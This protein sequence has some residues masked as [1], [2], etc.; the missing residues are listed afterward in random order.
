MTT[1]DDGPGPF[2]DFDVVNDLV[3]SGYAVGEADD[4]DEVL[5]RI[6]E[7][8][9]GPWVPPT[10]VERLLYRD[11]DD[12]DVSAYLSILA[13]AGVYH[14]VAIT[15]A[16]PDPEKR[17]P[18]IAELGDGLRAM[19]VYTLD[20]L[21][22]PHPKVVYEF[23]NLRGLLRLLGDVDVLL[24]NPQTPCQNVL[25]L[26]DKMKQLILEM[27]DEYWAPGYFSG[28]VITRQS[29]ATE[30]GVLL[31]GLACGAQLCV[32]NGHAWNT[33]E[34][35][36][37]GYSAELALIEEWW[38]VKIRQDWLEIEG[39]L[40]N[41]DVH[42]SEW[43]HVL[44]TRNGLVDHFGGPVDAVEWRQYDESALRQYVAQTGAPAQP[45]ADP[46]LD[47]FVVARGELITRILR[48]EERFREDGLLPDGGYVRSTAAW[49]LGRASMMARWGRGTRFCTQAEM[50]DALRVLSQQAQRHYTSWAEF[51]V[52][53]ILGRCIQFD[54]DNSR[55]WYTEAR[56][57]HEL[58]LSV[59][60][61]PWGTVPF[62]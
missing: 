18:I 51:G 50:F 30:P 15:H 36:G 13:T 6:A 40:L 31:H 45:G 26:G 57:N 22:R 35:H 19:S 56:E 11:K 43:D 12:P 5:P 25:Q 41:R 16:H 4:H 2:D 24:V 29:N 47:E 20:V 59:E 34:Y 38:G 33:T 49:D 61:S 37:N 14:P 28:R 52:G 42:S 1:R 39:R 7:P 23:T 10:P 17:R 8:T 46:E 3:D 60:H 32:T 9:D 21:P 27:H 48:F 53:Y 58:L 55:K 44:R 54:D 62:R